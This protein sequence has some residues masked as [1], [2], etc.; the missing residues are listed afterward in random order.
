[1]LMKLVKFLNQI[2]VDLIDGHRWTRHNR[3]DSGE[4]LGHE[5]IYDL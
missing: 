1:M 4:W 5:L 2:S 3:V